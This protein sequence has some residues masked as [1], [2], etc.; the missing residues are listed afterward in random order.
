MRI[1]IHGLGF[2]LTAAIVRHVEDGVN[3]S[4]DI[5]SDQVSGVSVRLDDINGDR[6]GAD[7]RCRVVISMR[8]LRT[9]VVEAVGR[10]LYAAVD[11]ALAR[12]RK[13]V[14]RHVKRRRTLRREYANR[15][16]RL[17]A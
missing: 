13:S 2:E 9:I 7:K 15:S 4:L 12:A 10:D 8:P 5:A 3:R 16:L 11:E 6:G 1:T 14:K 17:V